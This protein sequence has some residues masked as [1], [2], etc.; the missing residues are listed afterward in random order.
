MYTVPNFSAVFELCPNGED[1]TETTAV[2]N[3][4][5]NPVRANGTKT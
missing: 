2:Y 1:P 5:K 3:H 4:K